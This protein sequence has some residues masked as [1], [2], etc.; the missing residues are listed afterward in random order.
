M[1]VTIRESDRPRRSP[2]SVSLMKTH[3]S[4]YEFC[5]GK[6]RQ[7]LSS[8][9][10]LIKCNS[11]IEEKDFMMTIVSAFEDEYSEIP[12]TKIA[13]CDLSKDELIEIREQIDYIL[14]Y[15]K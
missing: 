4:L 12:R 2:L 6:M 8:S 3:K 1:K 13:Q 11:T 7:K 14:T 5:D 10:N 9:V 15:R